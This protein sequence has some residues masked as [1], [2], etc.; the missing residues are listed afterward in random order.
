[1]R[2]LQEASF[3]LSRDAWA[4]SMKILLL[5][6]ELRGEKKAR[7]SFSGGPWCAGSAA[8]D[9]VEVKPLEFSGNGLGDQSVHGAFDIPSD[10]CECVLK[11]QIERLAQRMLHGGFNG[12]S[13]L[14]GDSR[15]LIRREPGGR[16]GGLGGEHFWRRRFVR[17]DL[18][19]AASSASVLTSRQVS[20]TRSVRS[21]ARES[22]T[23]S[24]R[25]MGMGLQ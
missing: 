14:C 23:G 3:G 22:M 4:D 21:T 16:C 17:P 7:R 25:S 12:R 19:A 8:G 2:S 5:S 20:F 11:C 15:S 1:M 9:L 6:H 13:E 24:L 18:E 10:A